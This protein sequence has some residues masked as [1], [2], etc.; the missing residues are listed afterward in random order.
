MM[1]GQETLLIALSSLLRET[2]PRLWLWLDSVL[3]AE[4]DMVS[5]RSEVQMNFKYSFISSCLPFKEEAR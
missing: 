1:L 2:Q 3:S 4:T 5:S